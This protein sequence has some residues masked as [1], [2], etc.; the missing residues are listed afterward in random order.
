MI[1]GYD[2][3]GLSQYGTNAYPTTLGSEER[4]IDTGLRSRDGD[5]STLS[6]TRKRHKTPQ[7][8]MAITSG[9]QSQLNSQ[10]ASDYKGVTVQRNEIRKYLP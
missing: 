5:I 1:T 2:R 7:E 9:I 4:T 3:S 6:N 10:A 8:T